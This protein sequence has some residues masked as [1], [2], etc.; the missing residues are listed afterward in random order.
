MRR[1]RPSGR[2]LSTR[3][4][5]DY[6]EQRLSGR[7]LRRAQEHLSLP[8]PPCRERL[9]ALGA[10][11][12]VMRRDRTP[13]VP[14][15]LHRVA[16]EAFGTAAH[17][18]PEPRL[19]EG[20]ARLAFDSFATPA[21]AVARRAVG[22]TRLLR[23]ES[24]LWSLELECEDEPGQGLTLRG[25]LEAADPALYRIEVTVGAEHRAGWPDADGAFVIERV[26]H[27]RARLTVTGPSGRHRV[28][29]I[30]L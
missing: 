9:R 26:P 30:R 3:V 4:A 16:L 7:D 27:G 17:R 2:H 22:E 10:L 19:L 11:L 13:A 14:E 28:P 18:E 20:L 25:R 6:L 21:A 15:S 5:L 8:C 1:T 29:A 12:E 23:F 24:R